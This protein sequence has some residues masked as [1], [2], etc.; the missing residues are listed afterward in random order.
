MAA[1]RAGAADGNCESA[2]A[3]GRGGEGDGDA[4]WGIHDHVT[5]A[6]SRRA[7]DG[8]GGGDRA[9]GTKK[10]AILVADAG[11]GFMA[12]EAARLLAD[13]FRVIAVDPLLWGESKIKAQD[14]DYLFPLF[15]AAIGERPLGIQAAQLAAVARWSRRRATRST[16]DRCQR[17]AR[18]HGGAGG[19]GSSR[20]RL[21]ALN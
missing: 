2:G 19:R 18:E 3:F 14:P 1:Q 8:A 6:L 13:G 17:A 20:S 21:A 15:L 7:L 11:R 5:I 4:G 10:T 9:G 12:D 16:N